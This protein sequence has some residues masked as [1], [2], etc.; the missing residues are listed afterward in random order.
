MNAPV[1]GLE[2][3][4]GLEQAGRFADAESSYRRLIER[5]PQDAEARFNFACF[6]RRRGRLEEAL[7][8]HQAALDLAI[9]HPEE[10]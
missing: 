9:D 5:S 8:E 3:A 10:V 6:L 4:A 2:A 1:A 7:E